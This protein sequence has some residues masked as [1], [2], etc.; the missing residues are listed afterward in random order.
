MTDRLNQ[1]G[2]PIGHALPQWSPPPRPSR[3][4]MEG[5]YC[6]VELIDPAR[7]G[8]DLHKA[9][10]A[11]KE[12]RIWTYLG[13]GPMETL[14]DYHAW[15]DKECSGDDPMFH[16]II[17]NASGKAVGVAS[18]LRINPGAGSIEVGHINY[19]PAL[20]KTPAAT[21]AMYLMMKRAFDL[22]YRRYEWKCDARNAGSRAA[23]QRLGL[24][25]EGVFRQATIYKSRNRDTA[26]YAAIDSE[27]PALRDAFE[28]WLDPANFDADGRQR[29]SL[30]AATGP[31]LVNRG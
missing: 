9:N 19:A 31:L 11:D 3:Q 15:M 10:K 7:H 18:Y 25:Y 2:Q 20:Q 6:R 14:D 8:A 26:W 27:W 17:G 1:L 24:S 30:S 12:E 22:G 21:E 28:S 29:S 13:Y 4:P 16:A 5:R 23:A